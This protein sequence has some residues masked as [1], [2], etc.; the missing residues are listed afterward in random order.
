MTFSPKKKNKPI[1]LAVIIFFLASL[2]TSYIIIAL[3]TQKT[4]SKPSN[5]ANHNPSTIG[6]EA[7]G[8]TEYFVNVGVLIGPAAGA[9]DVSL[10]T[11]IYVIETRPV[12]VDL[13]LNPKTAVQVEKVIFG[14]PGRVTIL[15][16]D[17]H[18]QPNTTYNVSGSIMGL[19]AWW[20]F[21]TANSLIP[22]TEYEIFLSPY[23]WWIAIIAASIATAIFAKI[24]W[25][26]PKANKKNQRD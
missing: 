5:E 13:Q 11:I 3:T 24:I 16:P 25:K 20:T 10:D 1:I 2:I 7:I 4:Y 15:Y 8:D 14:H 17:E 6:G 26:T 23:A 19:S 12:A 21:T 22:Q 18:L 9:T